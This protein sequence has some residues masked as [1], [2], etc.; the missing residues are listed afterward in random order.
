MSALS[1]TVP[2]KLQ[3]YIKQFQTRSKTG[4]KLFQNSFKKIRQ[5]HQFI[6]EVNSKRFKTVSD[7]SHTVSNTFQTWRIQYLK[8]CKALFRSCPN[9]FQKQLQVC[10]NMFKK[11]SHISQCDSNPFQT[12]LTAFQNCFRH[13]AYSFKTTSNYI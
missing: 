1:Q 5:F 7:M 2:N 11:V 3:P 9:K 8:Q 10:L 4:L 6:L 13:V 12:C